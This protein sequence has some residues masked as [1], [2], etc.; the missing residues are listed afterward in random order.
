MV[1]SELQQ[2]SRADG[3][4]QKPRV[5]VALVPQTVV[6]GTAVQAWGRYIQG[7]THSLSYTHGHT[8]THLLHIFIDTQRNIQHTQI[9]T[10]AHMN[11]QRY[12]H[13]KTH[14]PILSHRDTEMHVHACIHRDKFGACTHVYT[15]THVRTCVHIET[16]EVHAHT[17]PP[18]IRGRTHRHAYTA[19]TLTYAQTGTHTGLLAH[20]RPPGCFGSQSKGSLLILWYRKAYFYIFKP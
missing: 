15:C 12:M 4:H 14:S 18:H 10:Q 1:P 6:M 20:P 19:H 8:D 7:H 11:T 16:H 13:T 9:H 2:E 5:R 3:T 17:R